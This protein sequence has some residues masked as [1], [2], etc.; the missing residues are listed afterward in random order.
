MHERFAA[1]VSA[2]VFCWLFMGA[3]IARCEDVI[4][5]KPANPAVS[6][7]ATAFQLAIEGQRTKSAVLML[8]AIEL[9]G[10]LK[11]SEKS[12]DAQDGENRLKEAPKEGASLD[13]ADWQEKAREYAGEDKVALAFV[14]ARIEQLSSRALVQYPKS[15]TREYFGNAAFAVLDRG[16]LQPGQS[17]TYPNIPVVGGRIAT[18]GAVGNP[19]SDLDFVITDGSRPIRVESFRGIALMTWVPGRGQ[20]VA[21]QVTNRSDQETACL[22]IS[23]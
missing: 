1:A 20:R 18:L 11:A 4:E 7:A 22:L 16:T 17:A 19:D 15:A 9:I 5:K 14:D 6:Q 13:P 8:A 23:D 21:V 10:G 12:L 3:T 2:S